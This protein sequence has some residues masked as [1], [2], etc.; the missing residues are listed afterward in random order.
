[1]LQEIIN[2]ANMGFVVVGPQFDIRLWNRWMVQVTGVESEVACCRTLLDVLPS[3]RHSALLEKIE[4]ALNDG[5]S[6]RLPPSERGKLS[7]LGSMNILIQPLK[8]RRYMH[9]LKPVNEDRADP[10]C[11][12]QFSVPGERSL[13]PSQQ[14]A[15]NTAEQTSA[16]EGARLEFLATIG[17]QIRTPVNGVLGVAELLGGT[18]LNHEQRKYVDLLVRSGQSLL[19]FVNEM[20]ELSLLEA[21]HVSLDKESFNLPRLMQDVM[22]LFASSGSFKG[23]KAVVDLSPNLPTFVRTD[24]QKLRQVLVNLLSNAFKFTDRG[25]VSLTVK[26]EGNEE[27]GDI[28]IDVTDTGVG[29]PAGR[30]TGLFEKLRVDNTGV[31]R[32]FNKTGLGLFICQELVDLFDGSIRVESAV[33]KGTT[34]TVSLPVEVAD[35]RTGL[36][37]EKTAP[38][39]RLEDA[40]P[41]RVLVAEDNPVNQTLIEKLLEAHGHEAVIVPNGQEAVRAMQVS[42][43]FDIILMD[44]SMPVMDGLEATALIRSLVG[45][46]GMTPIIALTAHALEGDREIFLEAGMDGYHSKPVDARKLFETMARTIQARD[47]ASKGEAFKVP[48]RSEPQENVQVNWPRSPESG[49]QRGTDPGDQ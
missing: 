2:T 31:T 1:M 43:K 42:G 17:H 49:L 47:K 13:A 27:S 39:R 24:M 38:D 20:T 45:G 44:I 25:T 21:G 10:L 36:A 37:A 14:P 9:S 12:I 15:H 19:D 35:E 46:R 33:G 3:I 48:G 26:Y 6:V 5:V 40:G 18:K 11:L 41:W 28:E 7:E 8:T 22:D 30:L 32:L 16:T 23:V 34:F 4:A 29:I